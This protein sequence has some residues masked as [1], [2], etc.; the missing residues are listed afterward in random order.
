MAASM[1]GWSDDGVTP[2]LEIFSR[3]QPTPTPF[4]FT[5]FSVLPRP[6]LPRV[7]GSR[8][9]G[10]V[11][12]CPRF[13]RQGSSDGRPR[14]RQVPHVVHQLRHGEESFLRRRVRRARSGREDPILGQVRRSESAWRDDGHDPVAEGRRRDRGEDRAG[15]RARGDFRRRLATWD[16]RSPW[17]SWPNSS[18]PRF[19]G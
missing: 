6:R 12:S 3:P 11:A 5:E 10:E 1:T 4:V 14:R 7:S 2:I 19:P 18:S 15:R 17:S 9:D 16:G 8:R 13:H